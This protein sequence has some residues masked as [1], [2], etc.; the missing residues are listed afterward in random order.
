MMAF[1]SNEAELDFFGGI[2]YKRQHAGL[3]NPPI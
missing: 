3:R 2:L 1:V